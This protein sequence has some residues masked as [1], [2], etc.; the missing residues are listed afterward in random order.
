MKT[1]NQNVQTLLSRQDLAQRWDLTPQA[2][3]N[4]EQQGIITRNPNI[5]TPRYS[6]LEIERI[7]TSGME[8]NPL[9]PLE[10]RKLEKR[11]ED[12]EKEL[13]EAKSKLYKIY[14][15]L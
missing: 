8:I 7:E 2:I 15:I 11:I 9:S 3:L 1:F 10:R 13:N 6:L 5:P 12:L 4:Y 14:S